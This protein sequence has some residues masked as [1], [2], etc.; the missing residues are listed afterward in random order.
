M[1][2]KSLAFA[3][4]FIIL[5]TWAVG[6]A[7]TTKDFAGYKSLGN[8]R[9]AVK[10]KFIMSVSF[11]KS[12]QAK[13][14]VIQP[15][16]TLSDT[17]R[18]GMSLDEVTGVVDEIV[19]KAKRGGYVGEISFLAGCSSI[20]TDVYEQVKISRAT[21]CSS[22]RNSLVREATITWNIQ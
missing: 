20:D 12:G 15:M 18:K 17:S 14:I 5:A 21:E 1:K 13:K 10:D 7:Q 19:P 16:N 9:Y 4:M 3:L 2:Y 6:F 8:G 22:E 11:G